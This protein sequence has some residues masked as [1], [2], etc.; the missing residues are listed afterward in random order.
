MN[1]SSKL[2]KFTGM[3]ILIAMTSCQPAP[4]VPRAI[5]SG[6][7]VTSNAS[8]FEALARGQVDAWNVRDT[9]ALR[10]F[11]HP[12]AEMYDRTFGDH[13]VGI[14]A[15]V[16]IM[17]GMNVAVPK[18]K[19][20]SSDWYIGKDGGLSVDPLWDLSIGGHAFTQGDLLMDVDWMQTQNSLVSVW[21]VFYGLDAMGKMGMISMDRMTQ[22]KSQLAAYEAAW[23]GGNAKVVS[24]LY[25]SEAVREDSLFGETQNGQAAISSFAKSFFAWYPSAPWRLTVAFGEGQGDAAMVGGL[26]DILVKDS[27]GQ[28]CAVKAGVLLQADSGKITHETIY[29]QPDSLI[30]CGWAR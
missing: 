8:V 17:N 16:G 7:D 26:F 30:Q 18:W 28:P 10:Q 29:Y 14:D 13:G 9:Q 22:S 1:R 4:A 5:L 25:A 12:D 11:Y 23:S 24:S 27:S 2:L 6:S 21:T 20:V 15:I 3:L 19:A